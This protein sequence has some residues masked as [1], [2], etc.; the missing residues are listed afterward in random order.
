MERYESGSRT[1]TYS[2]YVDVQK[3]VVAKNQI[4]FLI[5]TFSYI[6]NILLIFI[7]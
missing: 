2:I 7:I 4:I 1:R 3:H 6:F 5:W